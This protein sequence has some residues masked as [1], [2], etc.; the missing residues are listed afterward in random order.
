M[1][2]IRKLILMALLWLSISSA[3]AAMV[4]TAQLAAEPE[5]AQ[6][7]QSLDQ[8]EH[9]KQQLIESGVAPTEATKRVNQMTDQQ[10]STLQGE[11]A[12][13]PAGAGASTTNLLLIIIV[14]ILLL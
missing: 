6:L 13:L 12:E 7:A 11:I 5:R 8:R 3:F 10:I 1:T 9:V 4:P 14:L 2:Y